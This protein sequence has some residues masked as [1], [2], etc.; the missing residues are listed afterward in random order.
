MQHISHDITGI[1]LEPIVALSSSRSVGAEVL[2]VLS[3]HQQSEGFFHD[4]SAARALML[5]EA[6]IAAL[7][8]TFP[9][10]NLFINLPITVLTIP[11]MFQRLLQL[12]SPP[13]N[14]ELVEPA[15][16]FSL[17]DPA[18]LRVSCA[19]QQLTA[20]GHRI[21]LDDIDEASGRA[22]LSCRM[23]LSGIKIDKIAFWRLR[24]TPALANLV[25]LC[26]KIAEN[27][28]IEGIETET[29]RKFAL[30]AGA[31]FGQGYYWPSWRWQ[32]D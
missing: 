30:Q 29:D 27:V 32:E 1:K 2:S 18:R 4:W 7:K 23:P 22:F 14:I 24:A 15:S 25:T 8:K 12:K 11:E 28:L 21:W 10:D 17:S 5:L 20:Q 3:P 19:L 9:C 26:S 6:Q 13:L 31:R 16:F